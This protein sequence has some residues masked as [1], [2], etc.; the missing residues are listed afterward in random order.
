MIK[1]DFPVVVKLLL[2][3]RY[4]DDILKSLRNK[5]DA[6]DL[7]KATEENLKNINMNIKGWAIS[8]ED[9]P[10]QMSDDSASVGFSGLT[11][12]PKIDCFK[13]NISSLHFGKK[14]RGKH[15]S[16]LDFYE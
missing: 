9:P 13:L 11:W 6:L 14:K 1:M 16:N 15:S 4:V 8:G 7:I 12:F 3:S 10:E 5:S 2:K